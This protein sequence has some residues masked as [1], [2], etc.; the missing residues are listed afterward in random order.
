MDKLAYASQVATEM[1]EVYALNHNKTSLKSQYRGM[2]NNIKKK[3]MRN[4]ILSNAINTLIEI[5]VGIVFV[6]LDMLVKMEIV[7]KKSQSSN[8]ALIA[9]NKNQE[10]V[11]V[12][13]DT[14]CMKNCV[15]CAPMVK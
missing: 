9:I 13:K 3:D 15:Y 6:F 7:S 12:K 14:I 11:F 1:R 10:S 4:R 8:V 5:L 2:E